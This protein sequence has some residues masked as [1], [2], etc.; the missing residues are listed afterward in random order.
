[1]SADPVDTI[2]AEETTADHAKAKSRGLR[3]ALLAQ[4]IVSE[5][6]AAGLLRGS[7]SQARV[8]VQ[9][10]LAEGLYGNAAVDLQGVS[11]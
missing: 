2:I 8:P 7:E 1:M 11:L 9:R 5:L 3:V 10:M 4:L 6:N